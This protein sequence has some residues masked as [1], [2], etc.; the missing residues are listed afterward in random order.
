LNLLEKQHLDGHRADG[1][2]QVLSEHLEDQLHT[3]LTHRL[4]STVGKSID[5]VANMGWNAYQAACDAEIERQTKATLEELHK[6]SVLF[7]FPDKKPTQPW[8]R[9]RIADEPEYVPLYKR[10]TPPGE[11]GGP[12]SGSGLVKP[13]YRWLIPT[14]GTQAPSAAAVSQPA[15]KPAVASAKTPEGVGSMGAIQRLREQEKVKEALTTMFTPEQLAQNVADA[16]YKKTPSYQVEQELQHIKHRTK[17][18]QGMIEA[19]KNT[20]EW[21]REFMDLHQA[22][23]RLGVFD[24]EWRER[25]AIA[26]GVGVVAGLTAIAPEVMLPLMGRMAVGHL[27]GK[28][29]YEAYAS[30]GVPSTDAAF[31]SSVVDG[32][33]GGHMSAGGYLARGAALTTQ[34]AAA[35]AESGG[36]SSIEKLNLELQG[37]LGTDYRSITNKAGDKVFLSK[38][39]TRCVRF[40]VKNPHGDKPHMHIEYFKGKKWLDATSTHRIQFKD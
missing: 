7:K 31:L 36:L 16:E 25:Q 23:E 24:P 9:D 27:A 19:Q 12:N 2:I 20:P 6:H 11:G 22:H 40:D 32:A 28:A 38:D 17:E 3:A 5:T 34:A 13:E 30:M 39:G 33:T 21:R 1:F 4:S 37:Y 29:S 15:H 35:T 8:E 26:G 14:S 10:Y 18:M